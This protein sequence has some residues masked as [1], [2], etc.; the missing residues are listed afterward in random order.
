MARLLYFSGILTAF[1]TQNSKIEPYGYFSHFDYISFLKSFSFLHHVVLKTT[2]DSFVYYN[3]VLNKD[4]GECFNS[5]FCTITE[6]A[7]P[8]R[9]YSL[10]TY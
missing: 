7:Q 2:C 4:P 5:V 6:L 8:D 1:L 10:L 3:C 9:N